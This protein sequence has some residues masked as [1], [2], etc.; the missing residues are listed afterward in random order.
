M[1]STV[2]IKM[3]YGILNTMQ[4]KFILVS[5]DLICLLG[6]IKKFLYS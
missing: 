2:H 4:K 5:V 3:K 6:V 1:C